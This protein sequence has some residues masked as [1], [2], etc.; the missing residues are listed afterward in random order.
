MAVKIRLSRQGRKKR[1]FYHIIVADSRSPRD[2]RRVERIGSYNPLVEPP[3]VELNV[4]RAL[5]WL[6]Q[7]AQPT[8]TAKSI[9]SF[10]GV[11]LKKHLLGGVQKGA[12]TME[13]AEQRLA[14][15]LQEKEQQLAARVQ[16]VELKKNQTAKNRLEAETK[17]NR[18]RAE[19]LRIKREEALKAQAAQ[20]AAAVE[21]EATP[22]EEA[23]AQE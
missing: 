8:P 17:Q 22:Q 13:E 3:M 19:A 21:G 20:A 18:A 10:K 23:P 15:W 1:P 5:Y 2:G 12:F 11:L 9:L 6:Q 7:G 4:D 16:A 14:K